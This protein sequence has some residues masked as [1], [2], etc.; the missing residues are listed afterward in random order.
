[1]EVPVTNQRRRGDVLEQAIFHA[2]LEQLNAVGY[3]GVT[4]EGV[5][6]AARTGKASLYRRW[7]NKQELVVD[8]LNHLLPPFA[9]PPDTGDV[10][11]DIAAVFDQ[12][13]A[14]IN[15]CFGRAMLRL[16]GEFA[17]EPEFS[18][19]VQA[20]V[21][22]PRK[23][24]MLQV[25]NR[26]AARGQIAP[27]ATRPVIAEAGPALIIHR[28]VC[29]GPPVEA[30]FAQDVLDRVVMPLLNPKPMPPRQR[31]RADAAVRR[32]AGSGN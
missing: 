30:A 11:A 18:Q 15:S 20:R 19:V 12:L 5:A 3:S 28:L 24:V 26:A 9:D 7:P 1:M 21:L 13:L 6:A 23:A 17:R 10:R 29:A 31:S 8:A 22:A 2:V 27:E 14:V 16:V 32:A 25:L 4:M